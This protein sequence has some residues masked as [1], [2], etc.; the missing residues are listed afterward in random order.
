MFL[1]AVCRQRLQVPSG[2]ALPHVPPRPLEKVTSEL[3]LKPAILCLSASKH[4]SPWQL[5]I[6]CLDHI[7]VFLSHAGCCPFL[8]E[9]Q[10]CHLSLGEFDQPKAATSPQMPCVLCKTSQ[11]SRGQPLTHRPANR[12]FLVQALLTFLVDLSCRRTGEWDA[13]CSPC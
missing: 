2:V 3:G 4:A 5:G 11:E 9:S 6:V 8:L 12:V 7:F 13:S 1:S 10:W